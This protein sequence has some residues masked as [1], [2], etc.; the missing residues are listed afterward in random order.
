MS[1]KIYEGSNNVYLE[2]SFKIVQ[3]S[4]STWIHDDIVVQ[5]A[6]CRRGGNFICA[7]FSL[8][9]LPLLCPLTSKLFVFIAQC[10]FN[11]NEDFVPGYIRELSNDI[12][13]HTCYRFAWALPLNSDRFLS[14]RLSQHETVKLCGKLKHI[15]MEHFA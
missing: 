10:P 3:A 11:K 5:E 8:N 7:L 2:S 14:S 4:C 9:G 1:K 13:Q 12:Y 15:E 6:C